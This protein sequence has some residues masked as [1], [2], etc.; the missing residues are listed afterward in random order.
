M[1][2]SYVNAKIKEALEATGH[3]KHDAQKLVMTWA[4]RDQQ[5]LIGLTKPYLMKNIEVSV[6]Q[7]IRSNKKEK[8]R[9]GDTLSPKEIGEIMQNP[10]KGEK[11]SHRKVPPPKSSERQ[12]SVMKQIAA[13]FK[14]K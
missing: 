11:R 10:T 2:E 7:Y 9:L 5:L 8:A 12:A 3:D 1:T 13:A 6:E 14:K 4:V